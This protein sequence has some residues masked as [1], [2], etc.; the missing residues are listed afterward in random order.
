MSS[1]WLIERTYDT[2]HGKRYNTVA[3]ARFL[4]LRPGTFHARQQRGWR[5][6]GGG[7]LVPLEMKSDGRRGHSEGTFLEADLVAVREA[8]PPPKGVYE[9]E[10]GQRL[11]RKATAQEMGLSEGTIKN[12]E[13]RGELTPVELNCPVTGAR[14]TT[15][16]RAEVDALKARRARP[17]HEHRK[18]D[19]AWY[20][21][22]AEGLRRLGLSHAFSPDAR[23]GCLH[24]K[25]LTIRTTPVRTPLGGPETWF[26]VRE[27]K[28]A[29]RALRERRQGIYRTGKVCYITLSR[30]RSHHK[31]DAGTLKRLVA[32]GLVET[33]PHPGESGKKRE[34][35]LYKAADVMA[36][37]R[38]PRKKFNGVYDTPEGPRWN[39]RRA[40]R[41]SGFSHAFLKK[42][43]KA[44][45]FL[46]EGKLP[47]DLMTPPAERGRSHQE[48]TVLPAD[49]KRLR[50]GIKEALACGR[51]AG[52]WGSAAKIARLY[53]ISGALRIIALHTLLK[54]WREDGSLPNQRVWRQRGKRGRRIWHYDLGALATL[55]AG[56]TPPA[57]VTVPGAE[58]N[59]VKD[60][61]SRSLSD[62]AAHPVNLVNGVEVIE[63]LIRK[64]QEIL[65][66]VLSRSNGAATNHQPEAVRG[67]EVNKTVRPRWDAETRMLYYGDQVCKV[68]RRKPGHQ[69]TILSSFE[70]A[71]W[72][73][74]ID[75]PLKGYTVEPEARLNSTV[76]NLTH[77]QSH[78]HFSCDGNRG[79]LWQ[80]AAR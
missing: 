78:I 33:I 12:L 59:R 76:Y 42:Q 54:E 34:P 52:N 38:T 13:A 56:G 74:R 67:D 72:P 15:Y 32:D 24:V 31:V 8:P 18:I 55:L 61:G 1:A 77:S 26:H 10:D 43:I 4:G 47:S 35:L 27:V 2:P 6:L 63:P 16:A 70:K 28:R 69:E 37:K 51:L 22:R 23:N 80:P 30:V 41:Q 5:I 9:T 45:P 20:M 73:A 57:P 48:Y 46:P 36:Y 71:G 40:A 11:D 17:R 44:S 65:D 50:K 75:D 58:A 60:L 62:L 68:F 53:R 79:I 21:P 64:L 19:G 7:K 14:K 29:Q 66:A 39:L 3:A 25:G 49:L